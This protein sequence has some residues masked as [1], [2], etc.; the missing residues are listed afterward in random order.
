VESASAER[1]CL[2]ITAMDATNAATALLR[3]GRVEL[4]LS[5]RLPDA[6]ARE[7]ILRERLGALPRAFPAANAEML[8]R[9]SHGLS[10]A[11]LKRRR[12]RI[13]PHRDDGAELAPLSR[14]RAIFFLSRFE[15]GSRK[16]MAVARQHLRVRSRKRAR[17][18]TE[19]LAQNGFAGTR[20]RQASAE[21]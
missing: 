16:A 14:G 8:A 6:R 5:T 4:W 19:S 11:D 9:N 17:E 10:G 15:I 13:V 20:V 12:G 2:V 21:P 18:R 3:S 1:V 7:T